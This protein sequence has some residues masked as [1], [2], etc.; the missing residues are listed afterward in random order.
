MG[1]GGFLGEVWGAWC[2]QGTQNSP[3]SPL[4]LFAPCCVLLCP[5]LWLPR[6]VFLS[7]TGLPS[8]S[9]APVRCLAS[10]ALSGAG[11]GQGCGTRLGALWGNLVRWF[12][13]RVSCEICLCPVAALA[14]AIRTLPIREPWPNAPKWRAADRVFYQSPQLDSICMTAPQTRQTLLGSSALLAGGVSS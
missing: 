3:L 6:S 7:M 4:Y 5:R 11:T 12:P 1:R 2:G 8:V 9:S 10:C 13:V 14:R